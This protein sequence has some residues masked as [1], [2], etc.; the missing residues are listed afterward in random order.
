MTA[1]HESASPSAH[2]DLTRPAGGLKQHYRETIIGWLMASPAIVLIIMFLIVPFVMAFVWSFTNQRLIS[3]NPTEYVGTK[4]FTDLLTLRTITLHPIKDEATGDLVRD[5][6]GNLTYPKLRDY[7]RNEED[8]PQYFKLK[9]W[10]SWTFRDNQIYI[11][12]KDPVFMQ[13]LQNTLTFV[14]V[15]APGQG[16]LALILA[17][18][19]NQKLR[20]I[21]LFRTIFFMPVV[22]SMVIVALLWRFIYDGQNGLLNSLLHGA[23]F[24]AFKPVDWLGR[25]DTA[26]PAL[27]MMSVWQAV[28]F[29][30]VIWLS[31][32]QNIPIILYEAASVEGANTWQKFRFVTWPGLRSTA[33]FIL[34]VITMQ[35]FGLFTQVDVMTRGGPLDAT[36]SIMFQAVQRG[37]EKQ[38]IAG[39]SAISVVFFLLVLSVSLTQRYLTRE[40]SK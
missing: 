31:G 3:P 38:N 34:V 1:L 10:K 20:G 11:L 35:A 4:N 16:G 13:A 12:A 27:M 24:G 6:D 5:S 39:G 32:L 40:R 23:T 21:N 15:I 28:G 7:T 2:H 36:Q 8:Y 14:V 33:V 9:E 22:V 19:V 29:H 30:M 26:M 18:L 17:L 25:K 37:Y